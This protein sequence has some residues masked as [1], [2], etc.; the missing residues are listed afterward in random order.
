MIITFSYIWKNER[1]ANRKREE[2]GTRTTESITISLVVELTHLAKHTIFALVGK[3][4]FV[5]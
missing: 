4:V 5:H 1:N 2:K 3:I